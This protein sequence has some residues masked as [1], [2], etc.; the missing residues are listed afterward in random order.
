M[1]NS[2][3]LKNIKIEKPLYGG[4]ALAFSNG[5]ALFVE[6][7]LPEEIVDVE[8]FEEKKDYARARILSILQK[9][10]N[11]IVPECKNFSLCGGCSYLHVDYQ[12][13]IE[14]KLLILKDSLRRIASLKEESIPEINVIQGNRFFY[15]SHATVKSQNENFGFFKKGTNEF[16]AIEKCSLLS[17]NINTFLKEKKIDA[18]EFKIAE[19]YKGDIFYQNLDDEIVEKNFDFVY[20]RSLGTFY[21]GNKFLRDRM[22]DEVLNFVNPTKNDQF[23]DL[24]CGV[25]FFSLPL[26]SRC[27]SGIAFDVSKES[28]SF[29]KKNA[30]ANNLE[31]LKF[32]ALPIAKINPFQVK[33][34]IIVVDPPRAGL[35]KK[36]RHTILAISPDKI[37]Y[38]SCNPATYSRDLKFFQDNNFSLK[39]LS[40]IDMFPG[41]HHI[42][43]ISL[44]EK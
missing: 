11:R 24:A 7:A 42:E 22:I 19:N 20:Q 28:I 9:S 16:V 13:E 18:S 33:A 27:K 2:K 10:K 26:A 25:G 14:L 34:N 39:K 21:Q 3:I 29:A 6:N 5:K 23:L 1:E 4:D 32:F 38:V 43:L 44:L 40:F 41:T 8:I 12:Y 36:A 31:N 37:V 15:R 30:R 17:Q 35:S